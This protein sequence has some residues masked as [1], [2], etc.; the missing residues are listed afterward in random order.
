M[1]GF[2]GLITSEFKA[3]FNDAIDALLENT[4]LTTKTQLIYSGSKITSCDNCL[5]NMMTGRSSNKYKSGGPIPFST[6]TCPKCSGEGKLIDEQTEYLYLGVIRDSKKFVGNPPINN[7][8]E[9]IQ[10]VSKLST[11]S[12]L[13]KANKLIVDVDN[14]NESRNIFERAAEP[15]FIGFNGGDYIITL[16]KRIG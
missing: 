13:K 12:K 10:T 15:N 1:T 16:W 9:H 6:G 14:T 2:E 11:Y 8:N 4:A 3:L 7:P 5:I